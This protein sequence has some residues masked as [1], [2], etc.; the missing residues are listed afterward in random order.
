M[1]ASLYFFLLGLWAQQNDCGGSDNRLVDRFVSLL[2]IFI[3]TIL[4]IAGK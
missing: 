1:S 4:V 3:A 2:C